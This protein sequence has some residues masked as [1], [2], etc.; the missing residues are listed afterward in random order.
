MYKNPKIQPRGKGR[1]D[2]SYLPVSVLGLL[3][4]GATMEIVGSFQG[5]TDIPGERVL[6][7]TIEVTLA[8]GIVVP[9]YRRGVGYCIC[10]N[11]A[12][13]AAK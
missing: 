6:Y 11:M 2:P 3:P 12:F 5:N 10:Q 4:A 1:F 7:E 8:N 13:K 9:A